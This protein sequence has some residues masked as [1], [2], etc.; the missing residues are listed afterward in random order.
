MARL[1]KRLHLDGTAEFKS[2]VLRR[3]CGQCG[4]K[5]V[6]RERTHHGGHI[7]RLIGTKI[8]KFKSLLGSTGGSPKARRSY[9]PDKHAALTLGELEDWFAQH[10]VG[11]F[12][13]DPHRG[14]KGSTPAGAWALHPAPSPSLPPESLKRFR[15]ASC[16]RSAARC[17]AT[18]SCSSICATDTRSLRSG[19]LVENG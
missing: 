15:I 13:Q 19:W 5:L 18:A 1:P 6:Y 11:R 17:A 4:I 8:S 12:H 14:L 2:K 16:Q 7:E 10:I 9:D 3:G